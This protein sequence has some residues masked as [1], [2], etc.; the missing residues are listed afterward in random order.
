MKNLLKQIPAVLL[1]LLVVV[2]INAF[3]LPA[4]SWTPP[5]SSFP[6]GNTDG[7]LHRGLD[8]QE[9][10]GIL[11]S[12]GFKSDFY[13]SFDWFSVDS[14]GQGYCF[15]V[16]GDPT[17]DCITSWD[18]LGGGILNPGAENET[19]RFDGTDWISNGLLKN[20]DLTVS[21][22]RD[23]PNPGEATPTESELETGF[24]GIKKA[25]AQ[26]PGNGTANLFEAIVEWTDDLL[27]GTAGLVVTAG[28]ITFAD[29]GLVSFGEFVVSQNST[30][31]P[32]P[33]QSNQSQVVNAPDRVRIGGKLSVYGDIK[34][35]GRSTFNRVRIADQ[36][37]FSGDIEGGVLEAWDGKFQ[38]NGSGGEFSVGSPATFATLSNNSPNPVQVCA[39]NDGTLVL[40]DSEHGSQTYISSITISGGSIV[41]VQSTYG[42]LGTGNPN[43]FIRP[44]NITNNFRVQTWGAGGG[45]GGADREQPGGL[46]ETINGVVQIDGNTRPGGYGAAGGSAGHYAESS[47]NLT[48]PSYSIEVGMAGLRGLGAETGEQVQTNGSHGGQ[49]VFGNGLVRAKGGRGGLATDN[50]SQGSTSASGSGSSN[51]GDI[52]TQGDSGEGTQWCVG[53]RTGGG[54]GGSS[55]VGQGG[56]A[57]G[58]C[59]NPSNSS[60]GGYAAGGG[61][62]SGN[63]YSSTGTH[64]GLGG[65]GKIVI[66]W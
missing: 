39:E 40:C 22:K 11:Q 64:G 53:W 60:N 38:W 49:T 27:P 61:G 51:I 52:I 59:H 37:D 50:G 19:L 30:F 1:T 8:E 26:T 54:D 35:T 36:S 46:N 31:G 7:P 13:R 47:L 2:G 3:A 16:P 23:V 62:G 18:G 66:T 55:S 44:S 12:G 5:A 58:S 42:S 29:G 6:D 34:G 57:T 25:F 15:G 41:K 21:V 28:G 10:T 56:V 65:S 24:L 4:P 20:D 33:V 45:G 14:S 32:I 43:T 48:N 17:A 63:N 9:K